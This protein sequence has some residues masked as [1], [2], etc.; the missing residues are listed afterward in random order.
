MVVHASGVLR[1]RVLEARLSA[2]L[3]GEEFFHL[4]CVGFDA[5]GEFQVFLR[6]V[7]PELQGS[8]MP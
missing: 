4:P 3:L 6:D 5:D 7:I 1:V 2:V 8:A